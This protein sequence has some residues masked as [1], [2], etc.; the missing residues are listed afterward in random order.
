MTEYEGILLRFSHHIALIH[1]EL[2]LLSNII[3]PV[4]YP[5]Y[6]LSNKFLTRAL[7]QTYH[8][9]RFGNHI[10]FVFIPSTND[11]IGRDVCLKIGIKI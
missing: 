5:L 10:K 6:K 8:L 7:S 1:S 2:S 3:I 9:C 11:E 4:G